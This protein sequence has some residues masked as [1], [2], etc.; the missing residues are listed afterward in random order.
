ME[1]TKY[2]I[3][4]LI[5]GIF[6]A[7]ILFLSFSLGAIFGSHLRFFGYRRLH[8]N[9][10]PNQTG[11]TGEILNTKNSSLILKSINKRKMHIILSKNT[12]IRSDIKSIKPNRSSLKKGVFVYVKRVKDKTYITVI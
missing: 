7:I 12:I 5:G 9:F 6:A 10:K 2:I 4:S 11:T 8:N 3:I 1:K